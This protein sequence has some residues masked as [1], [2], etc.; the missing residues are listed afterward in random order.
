MRRVLVSI[1]A[2]ALFAMP[3]SAQSVDEIIAHYIKTIGGMEKIRPS[4]RCAAAESSPAAAGLR[5]WSGKKTSAAGQC[6]KS[7]RCRG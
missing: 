5:P 6:A 2:L 3:A 4:A 1:A 7:F